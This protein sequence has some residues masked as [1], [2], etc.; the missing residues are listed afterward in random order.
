MK[1]V[2]IVFLVLICFSRYAA[3]QTPIQKFWGLNQNI[4]LLDQTAPHSV[5][6]FA[7]SLRKLRRSYT[8]FSIRVRQG[9]DNAEADVA[10]DGTG[11]VSVNSMVTIVSPG[12]SSL[13]TGSKMTLASFKG[14]QQLFVPIWY[15]QGSNGYDAVHTNTIRHP[16]LQLN[17]A[18]TG[19]TKPS[20]YFNGDYFLKIEQPI[21]NIVADGIKGTFFT[22]LKVTQNTRQFSFGHR[23]DGEWRWTMHLNWA[24][25]SSGVEYAYFDA[26]E[27]CC[28]ND[29]RFDNSEHSL[30][31]NPKEG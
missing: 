29:R 21:Q 25:G 28:T 7:Y 12:S 10:F 23:K 11:I 13:S 16:E 22:A 3:A 19:N 27:V 30:P 31:L 24:V 18:G 1:L 26:G 15:D 9:T 4:Y 6:S 2:G 17:T 14:S 5:P 20:I 8:G